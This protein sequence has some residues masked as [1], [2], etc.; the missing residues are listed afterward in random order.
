M[1]CIYSTR[2]VEMGCFLIF[3]KLCVRVGR[4]R[5]LENSKRNILVS[6]YLNV[7]PIH[8]AIL[9]PLIHDHR[10]CSNVK[11]DRE[12]RSNLGEKCATRL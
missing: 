5:V 1:Q 12:V 4:V 2:I 9:F 6:K 10:G 7:A 8:G 11:N 3:F